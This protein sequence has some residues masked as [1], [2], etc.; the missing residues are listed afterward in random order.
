MAIRYR[1][2]SAKSLS[3]FVELSP[4]Y[5]AT[6]DQLYEWLRA[7]HLVERA[8]WQTSKESQGNVGNHVSQ[9]NIKVFPKQRAGSAT[10][11]FLEFEVT[12]HGHMSE[13]AP[14]PYTVSVMFKDPPAHLIPHA[15]SILRHVCR[16][17]ELFPNKVDDWIACD[18]CE[19]AP[20]RAAR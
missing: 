10:Q 19:E 7:C 16:G 15:W 20:S 8:E 3:G 12:H 18:H 11:Q 9:R 13:H 6:A 14:C 5:V 2:K 1:Y 17:K 4:M